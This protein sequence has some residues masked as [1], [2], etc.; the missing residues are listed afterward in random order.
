M[1]LVGQTIQE[2]GGRQVSNTPLSAG[3]CFM[4]VA[5]ILNITIGYLGGE[6]TITCLITD[7]TD[8]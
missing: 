8:D 6:G 3:F 1:T 5:W 4:W 7:P 2:T